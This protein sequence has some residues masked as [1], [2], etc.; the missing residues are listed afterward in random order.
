[1]KNNVEKLWHVWDIWGCDPEL[2]IWQA[3]T[4]GIEHRDDI[5]TIKKRLVNLFAV[6]VFQLKGTI[7]P[8]RWL[9]WLL[10]GLKTD[11][12]IYRPKNVLEYKNRGDI[13]VRMSEEDFLNSHGQDNDQYAYYYT[14]DLP[15]HLIVDVRN[16]GENLDDDEGKV[17][18]LDYLIREYAGLG[19]FFIKGVIDSLMFEQE[20]EAFNW[21]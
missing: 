21:L 3:K 20:Q 17:K 2:L 14:P 7:Y 8:V 1:M 9:A 4:L 11:Y 19:A 15:L 18:V 12:S 10:L 5:D 16:W 13:Y 6:Q